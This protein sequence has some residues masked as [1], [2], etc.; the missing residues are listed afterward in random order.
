MRITLAFFFQARECG[1]QVMVG[2]IPLLRP[3]CFGGQPLPDRPSLV[4]RKTPVSRPYHGLIRCDG[5]IPLSRKK[6][7]TFIRPVIACD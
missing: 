5:A 6:G 2:P 3:G 7:L 4:I 1:P